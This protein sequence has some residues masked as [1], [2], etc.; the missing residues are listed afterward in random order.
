MR[1]TPCAGWATV[2]D[3]IV[4]S[5]QARIGIRYQRGGSYNLLPID[6]DLAH[7]I[8]YVG[9]GG[10][11]A[12]LGEMGVAGGG[13]DGVMAEYLLYFKQVNARFDQMSGIGMTKAMRRN[14]FF[15]PISAVT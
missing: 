9:F 2:R 1:L 11:L 8:V 4:R 7:Q 3:R 15:K 6:L 13:E 5:E 10:F 14:S 12:L